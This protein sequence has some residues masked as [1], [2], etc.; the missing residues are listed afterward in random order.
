M[1]NGSVMAL[2]LVLRGFGVDVEAMEK[3]IQE[4]SALALE[5]DMNEL[6]AAL[7]LVL[8]YREHQAQNELRMKAILDALGIADPVNLLQQ[9]EIPNDD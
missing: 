5:F 7:Q 3:K 4:A 6:R 9:K 2:K 1:A 8:D